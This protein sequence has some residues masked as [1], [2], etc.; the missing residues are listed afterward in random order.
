MK[1]LYVKV[2]SGECEYRE[3]LTKLSEGMYEAIEPIIGAIQNFT[4]THPGEYNWPERGWNNVVVEELYSRF[5]LKE[6]AL[7]RSLL[8][9]GPYEDDIHTIKEIRLLEVTSDIDLLKS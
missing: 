8:P 7:F 2:D 1:Y 6:I 9:E 5:S 3:Q 4:K